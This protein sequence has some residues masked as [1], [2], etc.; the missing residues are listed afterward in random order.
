MATDPDIVERLRNDPVS[1][2]ITTRVDAI[3]EIERLRSELAA[4][5]ARIA[6]LEALVSRMRDLDVIQRHD[7]LRPLRRCPV[8]DLLAEARTEVPR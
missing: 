4:R 5:D 1:V 6:T 7:H 8:C 3:A 2:R